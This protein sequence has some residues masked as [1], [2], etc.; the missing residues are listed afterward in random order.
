MD[1]TVIARVTMEQVA[2]GLPDPASV[3]VHCGHR[4][5][6][7]ILQRDG[8][9]TDTG[10]GKIYIKTSNRRDVGVEVAASANYDY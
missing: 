6:K 4:R 7:T 1:S 2:L 10:R 5:A 3:F 8:N 9:A